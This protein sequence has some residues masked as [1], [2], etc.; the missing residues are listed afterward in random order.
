MKIRMIVISG[1][2]LLIISSSQMLRAQTDIPL[3][4]SE[5]SL[6][7]FD[8]V[9]T[10]DASGQSKINWNYS[11]V[12][13][14]YKQN[15]QG[16]EGKGE[17]FAAKSLSVPTE[18]TQPVFIIK[19]DFFV[20]LD[21]ATKIDALS[22]EKVQAVVDKVIW[23]S[24]DGKARIVLAHGTAFMRF[25]GPKKSSPPPQFFGNAAIVTQ[26]SQPQF[27]L[28]D[29]IAPNMDI[30]TIGSSVIGYGTS[31]KQTG[32]N[33]QQTF[34]LRRIIADA[35]DVAGQWNI[36]STPAEITAKGKFRIRIGGGG[37]F[38]CDGECP[39]DKNLNPQNNNSEWDGKKNGAIHTILGKVTMY[40]YEFVSDEK[41]PLTFK[42]TK[43][44]YVYFEGKGTVKD[45]N[46]GQINTQ[47]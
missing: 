24:D 1:V 21:E 35:G 40:D 4:K 47:N 22:S 15:C 8:V 31:S 16:L 32:T 9:T 44:G 27:D 30:T 14:N 7:R 37:A 43:D 6:D 45:L 33:N 26:T 42:L 5:A 46:T 10:F 28:G 25:T 12:N 11:A 20:K 38:D 34:I 41:A 39:L 23:K 17:I 36:S 19:G 29:I 18:G 13:G 3:V 2:L